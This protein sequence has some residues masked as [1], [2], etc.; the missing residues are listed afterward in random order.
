MK[1]TVLLSIADDCSAH[2]F[3]TIQSLL[4]LTVTTDACC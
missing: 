1:H 2:S 4:D 3:I